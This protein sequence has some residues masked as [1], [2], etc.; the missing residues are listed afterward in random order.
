MPVRTATVGLLYEYLA[1]GIDDD[2]DT[3]D[4]WLVE[5]PTGMTINGSSG[6]VL[7]TPETAG[8]FTVK[9]KVIDWKGGDAVQEFI[10]NVADKVK[11]KV[12]IDKP[13]ENGKVKGKTTFSGTTI[14]GTLEV[15][16]VQVRIDGGDWADAS[17][18]YT[19]Q[20]VLDTAKLKNGKHTLGARA[21][22]GKDYSDIVERQFAVDNQKAQGKGFIP[23]VDGLMLLAVIGTAGMVLSIKRR[24]PA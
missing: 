20:Y 3:L 17:G 10:I 7:W 5:A 12:A 8:N 19:W 22:D 2:K 16:S 6:K 23:M 11:A 18:N 1:K 13:A 15:L 14:K 9:I 21:F 4:F 24:K